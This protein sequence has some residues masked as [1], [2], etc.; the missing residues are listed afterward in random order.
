MSRKPHPLKGTTKTRTMRERNRVTQLAR[1]QRI[2]EALRLQEALGF[3]E[4]RTRRTGQSRHSR[5]RPSP[6]SGE[7]DGERRRATIRDQSDS[8][9]F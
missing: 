8:Q 2:S 1:W 4:G 6:D 7:L 9:S 3:G 5:A